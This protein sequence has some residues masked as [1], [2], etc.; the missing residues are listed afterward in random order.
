LIQLALAVWHPLRICRSDN[1]ES[2]DRG[3]VEA[4][5]MSLPQQLAAKKSAILKSWVAIVINSYPTETARF[6]NS[7][8]DPFANPVGQTTQEGLNAVLNL[9]LSDPLNHNEAR[10]ALD[11]IIRIR[12]IQD[13]TPSQATRFVFDLKKVIRNVMGVRRASDHSDRLAPE[14]ITD[15]E[16][17]IDELGLLAF[18]IYVKCREKIFEIKANEVKDRTFKA[19][20]RAGLVKGPEVNNEV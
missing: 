3:L 19:F 6:L 18:D 15:L 14:D 7:Q 11:P 17:R 16:T 20:A 8:K 13:F 5:H 9:L 2:S 10:Q 1:D 4:P 12:A